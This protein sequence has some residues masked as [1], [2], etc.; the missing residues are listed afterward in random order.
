M[1]RK[2]FL[3]LPLLTAILF[4]LVYYSIYKNYVNIYKDEL[5]FKFLVHFSIFAEFLA[6]LGCAFA[7]FGGY[8][9]S[10]KKENTIATIL[11]IVFTL[12]PTI[13]FAVA[14]AYALIYVSVKTVINYFKNPL[15]EKQD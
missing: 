7:V 8:K 3:L 11:F 14:V 6:F 12:Q 5:A 1:K 9:D 2:L 15:D 10:P 4:G 13:M